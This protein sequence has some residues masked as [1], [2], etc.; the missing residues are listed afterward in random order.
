LVEGSA[1]LFGEGSALKVLIKGEEFGLSKYESALQEGDLPPRAHIHI[2]ETL[3]P[4]QFYHIQAL[5]V[6]TDT[7]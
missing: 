1:R 6:M 2:R 3:V 7:L 4:R 5:R